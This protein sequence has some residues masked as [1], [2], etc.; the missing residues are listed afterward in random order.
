ME[1]IQNYRQPMVTATG[2]FLG[3]MLSFAAAW[4]GTA[5]TKHMFRDAVV[6]ISIILSITLLLVVLYRIL[7]MNYPA[8]RVNVYYQQ[9][10]R[11]FLTAVSVPFVAFVL[12]VIRILT[13]NHLIQ[14]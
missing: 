5:F 8:D 12:I 9:T 13:T 1:N 10:L 6:A 7:N 14:Q 2:I 4:V 11:L 3:F